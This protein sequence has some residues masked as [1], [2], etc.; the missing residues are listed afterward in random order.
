M[1]CKICGS[2]AK[3]Q[4]RVDLR[5]A[6]NGLIA[7]D[8]E[9]RLIDYYRCPNC[10]F[11]FTPYFDHWSA[12]DFGER[13]YNENYIKYDPEYEGI[14]SERVAKS[15]VRFFADHKQLSFLDYGGGH[16]ALADILKQNGYVSVQFFDPYTSKGSLFESHQAFDIVLCVE[17]MEHLNNPMATIYDM[18]AKLDR[19]K[20]AAIYFTTHLLDKKELKGGWENHWYIAPRN[21]HISIYA[22]KTLH[23]IADMLGAKLVS[24]MHGLHA[25]LFD[26]FAMIQKERQKDLASLKYRL[27]SHFWRW[28]V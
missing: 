17:V 25:F 18:V 27:K 7:T 14:R 20:P 12:A 26:G 19:N 1:R 2:A 6:C 11:V 28:N 3:S 4:M 15:F 16:G 9:D 22:I 24:N 8:V 21:G 23:R 5:K 10:S 13:I